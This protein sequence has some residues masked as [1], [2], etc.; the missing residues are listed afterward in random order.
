MM[1]QKRAS[2]AVMISY[3]CFG[4]PGDLVQGIPGALLR[5]LELRGR[6][7]TRWNQEVDVSDC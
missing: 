1:L 5:S 4:S 2:A 6:G 7:V 3:G